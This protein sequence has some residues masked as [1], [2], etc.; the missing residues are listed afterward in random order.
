M[1]QYGLVEVTLKFFNF[2]LESFEFSLGSCRLGIILLN[3]HSTNFS[4]IH[5]FLFRKQKKALGEAM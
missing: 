5:I 4:L 3:G 1:V 2:F